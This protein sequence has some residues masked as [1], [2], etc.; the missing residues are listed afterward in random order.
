MGLVVNSNSISDFWKKSNEDI[1]SSV[2]Y[3][4]FN[5]ILIKPSFWQ[6]TAIPSAVETVS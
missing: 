6:I 3:P 2:D 1:L 4:D 5:Q